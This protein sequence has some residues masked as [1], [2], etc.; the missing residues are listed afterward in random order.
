[1]EN[2]QLRQLN[3]GYC[4]LDFY[5]GFFM[6]EFS[7]SQDGATPYEKAVFSAVSCLLSKDRDDDVAVDSHFK[8]GKSLK[9]HLS[10]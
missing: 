10:S 4:P 9:V 8:V 7:C 2:N 5:L 6:L 1:M 3:V